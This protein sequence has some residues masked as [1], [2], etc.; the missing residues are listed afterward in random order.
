MADETEKWLTIGKIQSP[1]GLKGLVKVRSFSD[2][3]ERFLQPGK[4]WLQKDGETPVEVELIRGTFQPGKKLYLVQFDK[5]DSR[6]ASEDWTGAL[7]VVPQGDRPQLDEEEYHLADLMGMEVVEQ[8]TERLLGTVASVMAAG[9]D[10]LEVRQGDKTVLIPF[11]KV[12]VPVV[13]LDAGRI[14]VTP[15]EGLIPEDW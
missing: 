1:H 4:R 14:E 5:I 2:F 12:F 10:L 11:V 15:P 8:N 13:D 7:V 9:N 3:P 6:N